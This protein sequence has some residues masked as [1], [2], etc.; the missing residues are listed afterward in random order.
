MKTHYTLKQAAKLTRKGKSQLEADT[1][2]EHL[3]E[4]L[5]FTFPK[6][7]YNLDLDYA[8]LLSCKTFSAM[9]K[10]EYET[11][12][13]L[14]TP[15]P[16]IKLSQIL[17]SKNKRIEALEQKVSA[18]SEFQKNK[19]SEHFLTSK[20][21]FELTE[22]SEDVNSELKVITPAE[23]PF[24]LPEYWYIKLDNESQYKCAE[25]YFSSIFKYAK[26]YDYL[27][28]GMTLGF[29]TSDNT[30][31]HRYNL[32]RETKENAEE[33]TFDQFLTHVYNPWK[34]SQKEVKEEQP[35]EVIDW[36][37]IQYVKHTFTGIVVLT[38]G[39][40][41]NE[42]ELYGTKCFSGINVKTLEFRKDWISDGFKKLTEP[43]TIN[44]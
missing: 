31:E 40:G 17:P 10:K 14:K 25:E 12:D 30:S 6:D 1:T 44:P 27:R 37:K 20:P 39:K 38:D 3:I 15:L 32:L 5:K 16:I 24:V 41:I 11:N 29:V 13:F 28:K 34:E 43:I 36:D 21:S 8:D 2:K 22:A 35:Q 26:P 9:S 42:K 23:K 4:V 33:I 19:L 18:L 7:K